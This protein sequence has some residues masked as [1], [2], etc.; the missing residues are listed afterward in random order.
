LFKGVRV[1]TVAGQEAIKQVETTAIK[2]Q[3][4]LRAKELS[5]NFQLRKG[6]V[7]TAKQGCEI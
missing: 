2:R 3:D 1:S 7:I 4:K 6:R 5:K